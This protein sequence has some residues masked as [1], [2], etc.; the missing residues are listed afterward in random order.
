MLRY[1]PDLSAIRS[2]ALTRLIEEGRVSGEVLLHRAVVSELER[3]ASLGDFRGLEEV[4]QAREVAAKLGARVELVGEAGAWGEGDL[5][6]KVREAAFSLGAVLVTCDYVVAKSAEALGV[7]V[8]YEPPRGRLAL[9]EFF[10]SPDVMSVHLKEGVLPRV[11]RGTP[12]KWVFEV[13][14]KDAIMRAELENL[15]E[16]VIERARTFE[17][18]FVEVEREGSTIVQL[19]PYRIVITRPPFSDGL[20]VTAVRPIVKLSLED[21]ALPKKLTDR[22]EAQAEG[23]LIAGAP[24][25]GKTTFA[26]ALAEFYLRKGKVVKTIEAPR[27]LQLPPEAT[28]YSKSRS[29]S[30]EIHDILLLSRPDYTIFDEMRD[31]EDFKLFADLRLA[32]VGMVG[33]VHATTPIDAIQRFVGR[34]ELGMIPSVV[35]TVVF[36]KNGVVSKVYALE[37]V[38]KVPHGLREEDLAR[39]VVVVKDFLTEEPEYELYVFGERTFVVPVKRA[40]KGLEAAKKLVEEVVRKFSPEYRVEVSEDGTVAIYVPK[41]YTS[42]VMKKCRKKIIRA[43]RS[44]GVSAVEVYPLLE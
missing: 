6:T 40:V 10:K 1:I 13:V 31:T 16:E 2:G 38:V 34:V 35:D 41:G 33:V 4:R 21:Y 7:E 28:Q 20:E 23:I 5:S 18:G 25:M 32:G 14:R 12:G 37:T 30:E 15:I 39:P 17:D 29:S 26:Q 3:R 44:V 43:G 11:K 9:E 24:G 36:I 42:I 8:L 27:D 22:L 19:G